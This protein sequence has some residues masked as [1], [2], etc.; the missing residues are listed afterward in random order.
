[1]S[2]YD[3]GKPAV[4]SA[5]APEHT[6][7]RRSWELESMAAVEENRRIRIKSAMKASPSSSTL[8]LLLD[9]PL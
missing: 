9:S 7:K 2:V 1:V 3:E 4:A 6:R 5:A 8:K